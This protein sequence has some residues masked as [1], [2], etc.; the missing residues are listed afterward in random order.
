MREG[1]CSCPVCLCVCVCV[2]VYVSVC[3]SVTALA[4]SFI[5]AISDTHGFLVGF[6]WILTRG[7]SKNACVP[8]IWPK[9]ANMQIF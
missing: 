2:R 9:K 4:A 5:A 6:S 8:E 1:Y 7:L 3:L